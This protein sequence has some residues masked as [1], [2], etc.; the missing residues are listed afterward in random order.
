M[1]AIATA[2]IPI[3][4]RFERCVCSVLAIVR[5]GTSA[6]G[7][8]EA[9]IRTRPP[10]SAR[11]TRRRNVSESAAASERGGAGVAV[12]ARTCALLRARAVFATAGLDRALERL[13][14]RVT[15]GRR[16]GAAG[17]VAVLRR[18]AAAGGGGGG[19][20]G[21]TTAGAGGWGATGWGAGGGGGGGGAGGCFARAGAFGLGS[22][23]G[24][25]GGLRSGAGL[26]VTGGGG[27]GGVA[28]VVVS[29][30][31]AACPATATDEA[32]PSAP[33]AASVAS[34]TTPER[35]PTAPA[36]RLIRT[37]RTS[38]QP[39]VRDE[40]EVTPPPPVELLS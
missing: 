36:S 39:P 28:L 40:E 10:A 19:E 32:K 22:G 15:D 34:A 21:T 1:S 3:A 4:A 13:A 29:C 26:V 35:R 24:G 33:R 38:P 30:S 17:R 18:V 20:G 2:P 25:G 5:E 16:F 11:I 6:S 12:R 9:A 37:N 7:T 14:R 23:F 8:A 31:G 27:A